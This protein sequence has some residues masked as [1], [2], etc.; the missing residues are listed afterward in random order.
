MRASVYNAQ[1]I[2][3]VKALRKFMEE[4]EVKNHG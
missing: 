2:E 4:F 1:S 3:A